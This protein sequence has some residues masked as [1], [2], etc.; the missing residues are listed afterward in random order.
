MNAGPVLAV[1]G[2]CAVLFGASYAAAELTSED[3][4][5]R[6]QPRPAVQPS[7]TSVGRTLALG[8]VER[9][10]DLGRP[11]R[12]KPKPKPEAAPAA[13][14]VAAPAA[15]ASPPPTPAPAPS[16]PPSD[17]PAPDLQPEAPAADPQPQPQAPAAPAPQPAAP[18]TDF[19]DSDG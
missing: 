19:Y 5:V 17:S 18:S 3:D 13:R 9:L 14:I 4:G 10:P 7:D 16:E 2:A 15:P 8:G 1:V 12:P 11:P 6:A